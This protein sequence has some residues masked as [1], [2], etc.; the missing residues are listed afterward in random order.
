[1]GE[2][3]RIIPARA[4]FT[5]WRSTWAGI[6]RDHP[7][8]RGVYGGRRGRSEGGLGSS[9]LARGLPKAWVSGA[10]TIWIIPARAGFTTSSSSRRSPSSDHPRSRGVYRERIAGYVEQ[11]GSSPLARGLPHERFPAPPAAGIIPARA[12]FTR[13]PNSAT[14]S[15]P[16]HPRSRGV[17]PADRPRRQHRQGSSPLARGLLRVLHRNLLL[18][19]IIPARAGF[20]L[21]IT[22]IAGWFRGSSPLARGL[23]ASAP[24]RR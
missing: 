3:V 24:R 12:G 17:Y 22:L 16:D 13:A 11:S 4:G 5:V 1:M 10:E 2:S 7:R 8:S 15:L 21:P 19:G 6:L 23:R 14:W 18:G 9:P 20:T